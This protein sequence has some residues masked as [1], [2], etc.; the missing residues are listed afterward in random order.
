MN[1]RSSTN[2]VM[3]KYPNTT[4]LQRRKEAGRKPEAK[5]SVADKMATVSKLRDVQQSLAPVRAA[6]KARRAAKQIKIR[7]KTS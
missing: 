3:K 1:K 7:I 2:L 6:N 4:E 5:R